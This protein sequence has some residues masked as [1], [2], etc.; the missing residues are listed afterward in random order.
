MPIS[1]A[2]DITERRRIANERRTAEYIDRP[3]KQ[4]QKW[5]HAGGGPPFLKL[6]RSVAYDLDL[7]DRWLDGCVRQSTSDRGAAA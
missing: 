2:L 1:K 7:V 6:G 4:L 5:R 3:V